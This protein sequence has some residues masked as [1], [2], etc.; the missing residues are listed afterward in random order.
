M[1]LQSVPT[2]MN[3]TVKL[4]SPFDW[5]SEGMQLG[6]CLVLIAASIVIAIYLQRQGAAADAILK[7]GVLDVEAPWSSERART[8]QRL[9]GD[10]G[11]AAVRAQTRLDFVFLVL[12]PLAISLAVALLAHRLDGQAGAIGILI[13]WGVLLACP[14]DAIENISMLRQLSGI[15]STPWPQLSTICASM[16]FTLA[17]GGVGFVAAGLVLLLWQAVRAHFAL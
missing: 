16:K 6:L 9:L 17:A 12:Y 8:V 2:T 5:I 14:L 15:T 11:I 10:D 13:S 4:T 7:Y 3:D 1:Q